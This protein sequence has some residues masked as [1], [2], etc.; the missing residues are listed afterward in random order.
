MSDRTPLA[1]MLPRVIGSAAGERGRV[2]IAGR[3]PRRRT[4]RKARVRRADGSAPNRLQNLRGHK[5]SIRIGSPSRG[6]GIGHICQ[7]D[8]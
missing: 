5:R 3:I 2:L 8:M 7:R 6:L 4:G 1:R